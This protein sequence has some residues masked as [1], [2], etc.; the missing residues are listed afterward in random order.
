IRIAFKN[1][2]E[3]DHVFHRIR[4]YPVSRHGKTACHPGDLLLGNTKV[5]FAL[6]RPIVVVFQIF[7]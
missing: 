6:G 3:F 2:P 7:L 4:A 1:A 5:G